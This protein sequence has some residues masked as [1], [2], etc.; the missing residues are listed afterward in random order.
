MKSALHVLAYLLTF[1]ILV[2]LQA[3]SSSSSHPSATATPPLTVGA[4]SNTDTPSGP[5]VLNILAGGKYRVDMPNIASSIDGT[6]AIAGDQATFTETSGG[7]CLGNPGVYTVAVNSTTVSF[8]KVQDTCTPRVSD[9][10]SGP[11]TIQH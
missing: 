10:T 8:K 7:D 6:V 3:C 1:A 2:T 4:Y 5:E 11:W 9:W